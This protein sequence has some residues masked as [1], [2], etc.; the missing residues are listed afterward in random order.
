[1]S[2]A[3]L[4][5]QT[6]EG[7]PFVTTPDGTN[8]FL[9]WCVGAGGSQR[10]NAYNGD[11]G[12]V[13]FNGG[14]VNELMTGTRKWNTA[15]AARGRIYFAADNKVYAFKVPVQALS[16]SSAVSRKTHGA[17]GDF[18]ISLPGIECRSGGASDDYTLVFTFSNNIESGNAS[19]T[20]GTGT[21][22]GTPAASG[23]TLTVN[24]TGVTTAQTLTVTLSNVTDQYLQVLPDTPLTMS[25]L[26]GDT[27][28]N[29]AVNSSDISQTKDAA[30]QSATES[31][32]REDVAVNGTINSSDISL[33][34]AHSGE[35]VSAPAKRARSAESAR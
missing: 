26:I 35:S 23:N 30:G 28:G 2:S 20:D 1:M 4:M 8:D 9:V 32:F 29:G 22:S 6:G 31:N 10:L 17:A 21:V 24:L 3:W 15:I 27:N 33:V 19:V 11:T 5:T 12:A 14:G 25:V 13:V 16:L 34:K 18:D 7:S